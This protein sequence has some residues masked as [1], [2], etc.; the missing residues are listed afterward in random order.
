L[1]GDDDYG[2]GTDMASVEA[3]VEGER[4]LL[5]ILTPLLNERAPDLVP[6]V[7]AQLDRLDAAL[8]ATQQNG[9]W[10]AVAQVPLAQRQQVD[11][12]MGA[13]LEILAVIPDIMP[14]TGSNL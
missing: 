7:T 10:V 3:D 2:S 1:S 9:Q 5:Q 4:V 6:R 14:V 8:A 11:G 13:A 12:A